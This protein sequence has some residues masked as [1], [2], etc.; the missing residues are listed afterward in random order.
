[1]VGGSTPR[2]LQAVAIGPLI[3]MAGT[4]HMGL[5]AVRPRTEDLEEAASLVEVG[6]VSPVID[7]TYTL[8]EVP[9]ALEHLGSGNA[10]G[11]LVI[12]M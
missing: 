2:L 5:L 10:I 3:S 6:T 11:K 4:K 12:T 8:A 9:D 7:R 1:M